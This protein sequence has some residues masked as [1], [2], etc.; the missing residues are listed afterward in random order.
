MLIFSE[1]FGM[2]KLS[3]TFVELSLKEISAVVR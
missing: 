1:V 2:L 3:K